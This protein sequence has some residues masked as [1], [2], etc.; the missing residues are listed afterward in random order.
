MLLFPK[1]PETKLKNSPL[2]G[3]F[4]PPPPISLLR[5]GHRRL[6]KQ[7][8]ERLKDGGEGGLRP[9]FVGLCSIYAVATKATVLAT[10]KQRDLGFWPNS[11]QLA[12][13]G[14]SSISPPPPPRPIVLPPPSGARREGIAEVNVARGTRRILGKDGGRGEGGMSSPTPWVV[15]ARTG[16]WGGGLVEWGEQNRGRVNPDPPPDWTG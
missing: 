15:P 5:Q 4:L 11:C 6:W 10:A 16:K 13:D 14:V 7:A 1:Q 2:H 9:R 8:A 12:T 3:I